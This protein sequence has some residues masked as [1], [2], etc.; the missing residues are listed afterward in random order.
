MKTP[1]VV[2]VDN[3]GAMFMSENMSTGQRTRHVDI[4]YKVVREFVEKK[5]LKIVFVKTKEYFSRYLQQT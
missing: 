5:F 2:C 3:V 4:R 1:I